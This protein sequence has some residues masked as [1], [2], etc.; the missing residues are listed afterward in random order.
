MA[1]LEKF[2]DWLVYSVRAAVN[3]INSVSLNISVSLWDRD[4]LSVFS[5]LYELIT[6]P[7][8]SCVAK[9]EGPPYVTHVVL[10]PLA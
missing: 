6:P 9:R 5:F 4:V 8:P 2:T 1:L 7:P 10:W 3:Q